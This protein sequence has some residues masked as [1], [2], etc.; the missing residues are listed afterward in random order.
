M[1]PLVCSVIHFG[2]SIRRGEFQCPLRRRRG[3]NAPINPVA[4]GDRDMGIAGQPLAQSLSPADAPFT[5][6]DTGPLNTARGY[7]TA[8]LLP[9]G[10][11]LVTGGGDTSG[12][13]SSANCTTLSVGLGVPRATA[14][15]NAIRHTATL[16][17]NG[18][19]LVAGGRNNDGYLA[20]AELYDPASG[21]WTY[22][23]GPLNTARGYHTATLLPNGQVLVAGGRNNDGYLA[24]AELYDPASGMWTA[25]GSLA[26]A[27]YFHTATLLPNGQM[28]VAAGSNSSSGWLSSAELYDPA[29]GMWSATAASTPHATYTRRRC[30]PTARCWWQRDETSATMLAA[31]TVRPGQRDMDCYGA[32]S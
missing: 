11:V 29:S 31:R 2:G 13:L 8:T 20:S 30:C 4:A 19:V 15:P 16:L 24:S 6:S 25:T 32:A 12:L 9:N 10:Q 14:T 3:S 26:N 21:S 5:F 18:Q 23:T 1:S 27:R 28:L 22:T 17:P 7:H